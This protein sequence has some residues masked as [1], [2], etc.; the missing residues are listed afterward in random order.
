MHVKMMLFL[1]WVLTASP[2]LQASALQKMFESL[3]GEVNTSSPGSFQD[4]AHGYY[5]GGGMVMRQKSKVVSPFNVSLPHLGM[6]CGGIDM[7]F[8]SISAIKGEEMVQLLRSMAAGIPTYAFQLAM[9]TMAPQLENLMAQIRKTVQDMNNMMLDSCQM[10]Q[11]IVGGLFP[12]GTAASEIICQDAMRGSGEDWFGARKHCQKEGVADKKVADVRKKSPDLLQGEYN[13]T[14]HVLQRMPQYKEDKEFCY[15]IMTTIGTL[16]SRKDDKD[17]QGRVKVHTIEGKGDQK[18]YMTAYLKGGITV[19]YA[20]DENDRCLNPKLAE[21]NI[22]EADTMKAKTSK[23]IKTLFDKYIEDKKLID[24]ELGF[25]NDAVNLPVYRY[26]QVAAAAGT[27]FIMED[28][29]EYMA[30]SVLLTQFDKI[31]SEIIE[32]LDNLQSIQLESTT[33]DGFKKNIQAMRGHIQGMM[34]SADSTSI[35]RLTQVIQGYEH[36]LAA[37]H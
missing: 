34:A 13:L 14:W 32:A 24:S 22:K 31:S 9:K 27:P 35:W 23:M 5:T 12:T 33:I 10:S 28:A 8:G 26:I 6:G 25:L 16:I 15:F 17:K 1:C 2:P 7:Y 18:S 21:F 36:A 3:G 19:G 20:C 11:N 29:S 4:Q 37:K 30:L